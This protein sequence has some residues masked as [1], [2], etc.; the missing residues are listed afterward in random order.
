MAKVDQFLVA[1]DKAHSGQCRPHRASCEGA[2]DAQARRV[3]CLDVA[4]R[5]EPAS[6]KPP[7]EDGGEELIGAL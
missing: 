5:L 2:R 6:T 4:G 3:A 7:S 1:I